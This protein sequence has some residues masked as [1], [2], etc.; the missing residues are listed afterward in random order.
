VLTTPVTNPKANR[1]AALFGAWQFRG[2]TATHRGSD[3]PANPVGVAVSDLSF[4]EGTLSA[5]ITLQRSTD[6]GRVVFGM[7]LERENQYSIG[8]GG[9]SYAYWLDDFN[10]RSGYTA[11]ASWGPPST[12]T[13]GAH[14]IE[15]GLRG[16]SI[17]FSVDGIAIFGTQLPHPLRG[18]QVGAMA[19]GA[20][21]RFDSVEVLDR[22]LPRAFVVMSFRSMFDDLYHDV[23]D[24]V[25]VEAG[26]SAM[27]ADEFQYPGVIL[28]DI[29]R[30]LLEATV[31]IAEISSVEDAFNAN[32]FYE[33]GYA[34]A[35]AK[36][37]ILLARKNTKL[38]FDVSGYRVI[39]YDDS[40]GG[41]AIVER[42]L[43]A[44]LQNILG[45]P[46]SEPG[47]DG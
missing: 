17:D 36:P 29:E 7:D 25:C 22:V 26:L 8:I 39:L 19:V 4:R 42:E 47:T 45:V 1:W 12:L 38:P 44:H 34:H 9:P 33:L 11:I 43:R 24:P 28:Q 2:A 3:D 35:I 15:V 20:D 14:T 30:G 40:I 6:Q 23:I 5:R 41:K 18:E 31:V 37:T 10:V 32:V 16:Q 46:L 27:R 21:V 13:P